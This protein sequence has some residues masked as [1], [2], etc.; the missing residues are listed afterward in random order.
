[1]ANK[2][3]VYINGEPFTIVSD[4]PVEHVQKVAY[5]V[6]KK[7][8]EVTAQYAQVM[9]SERKKTSLIALKIA[10]E[11]LKVEPEIKR[12]KTENERL[13]VEHKETY[14]ENIKLTELVKGL[15]QELAKHKDNPEEKVISFTGA[16]KVSG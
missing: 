2:V 15:R 1:M 12:L 7:I 6:T 5:F 4:D 16:K 14:D 11:Y 8:E 3:D 10:D 9:M 13:Q